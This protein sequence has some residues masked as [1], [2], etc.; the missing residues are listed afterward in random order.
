M[1]EERLHRPL[2]VA[3]FDLEEEIPGLDLVERLPRPVR[4]VLDDDVHPAGLGDVNQER[5]R[6]DVDLLAVLNGDALSGRDA[7]TA[8]EGAVGRAAVLEEEAVALLHDLR[9]LRRHLGV[10]DDDL[11]VRRATDGDDVRL[12]ELFQRE[13]A[14][15]RAMLPRG[16]RAAGPSRGSGRRAA[17]VDLRLTRLRRLDAGAGSKPSAGDHRYGAGRARRDV[18]LPV[19]EEHR[20]GHGD[21]AEGDDPVGIER[22]RLITGDLPPGDVGTARR[23]VVRDHHP[24]EHHRRVVTADRRVADDQRRAR[25][26]APDGDVPARDLQLARRHEHHGRSRGG[27]AGRVPGPR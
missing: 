20:E 27:R 15:D 9:V 14:D 8:H 7:L 23:A 1:I 12:A 21:G 4:R 18:H 22:R 10:L 13:L 2:L 17:L 16:V 3:V 6:A 11:V 25:R 24:V 26:L 5:H 19:G